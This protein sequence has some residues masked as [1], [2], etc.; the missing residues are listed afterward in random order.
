MS[1]ML[2]DVEEFSNI[3]RASNLFPEQNELSDEELVGSFIAS[4]PSY[5]GYIKNPDTILPS[6]TPTQ[7][8]EPAQSAAQSYAST[9]YGETNT[10]SGGPNIGQD[11]RFVGYQFQQQWHS[12]PSSIVGGAAW[13]ANL[14]GAD[15]LGNTLTN[16]SEEM[17]REG[18]QIMAD[19]VNQDEELAGYLEWM[20]DE[21]VTLQNWWH[22]DMLQ[23]GLAQ[24]APSIIQM[25][26]LS[27]ATGG[28]GFLAG[29]ARGTKIAT[30]AMNKAKAIVGITGMSGMEGTSQYQEAMTH[31]VDEK[32][33]DPKIANKIAGTSAALYAPIS[34]ALEFLP[35]MGMMVFAFSNTLSELMTHKDIIR[36]LF[37]H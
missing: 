26:G 17:R 5:E 16:V 11:M 34:G 14:V 8:I 23:R 3:L 1:K 19:I 31:L 18:N 12:A 36:G 10:F 27:M 33:Y 30:S 15:S 37:S 6:S 28:V 35:F 24:A 4:N 9:M 13:L 32:G 25:A 29:A 7:P 22:I 2:Y 20:E 21:P